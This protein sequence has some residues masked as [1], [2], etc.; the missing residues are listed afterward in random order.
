MMQM[1]DVNAVTLKTDAKRTQLRYLAITAIEPHTD[2]SS[3]I[4]LSV[5]IIDTNAVRSKLQAKRA[6]RS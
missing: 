2:A 1:I 5:T 3:G 4:H 6:Q